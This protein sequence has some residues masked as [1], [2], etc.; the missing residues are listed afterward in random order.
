M[1]TPD[2]LSFNVRIWKTEVYT[3][4]RKTTYT[5]RWRVGKQSFREPHGSKAQADAFRS[6]LVLAQGNGEAFS[7]RNGLPVSLLRS[8]R[9][10]ENWLAFA[11]RY[12]DHKWDDISAKH[13]GNIAFTLMMATP[14]M[15]TTER[16]K[17]DDALL[18]AALRKWAFSK[19]RR[20][21][22]KAP[23]EVENALAW[24][25]ENTRM[26]SEL[27]DPKI[28]D[29]M[30]RASTTTLDGAKASVSSRK[31]NH[32]MLK[33]AL[34]FA[35]DEGILSENPIGPL[36]LKAS[37][38]AVHQ[39]D[40]RTVVNHKQA[41]ALLEAVRG[42]GHEEEGKRVGRKSGP[43]LVAFFAC[44]YY[45]G[46]RPEEA[47]NLRKRNL[48][49]TP[50]TQDKDEEGDTTLSYDW[51]WI[52][53]DEVTPDAQPEFTDNGTSR[54]ERQQLKQREPG[55]TRP[56]PCP[57]ELTQML[58]EHLERFG[59]DADG[60]LFTGVE[61]KPLATVTYRRAWRW[62]R[63]QALTGEEQASPLAATPY[64]LRHTCV[65]TWLNAGV[66]E[67]QVAQWAGHSVAVLK[68]IYAKCIVGEEERAMQQIT[69][70]LRRS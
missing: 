9:P 54:D 52:Y 17:P 3:G 35:V 56:V 13:R 67:T 62:A 2:D 4:A 27:A 31:R 8:E 37:A 23:I 50:P 61:G 19:T 12:V 10:D 26:V 30:V 21:S 22:G 63:E 47:I 1:H 11:C 60:R 15:Y 25:T 46:F 33:A 18:R 38:Q 49:L 16:G 68:R 43:R 28:A 7:L 29:A 70:A 24:V 41:R 39:V 69:E 14:A 36:K 42:Y 55:V 53:L 58:W 45:C 34:Q 32:G 40:R 20:H 65:S 6:K 57:P 51:S 66:S 59:T 48:S 5:V 44:M 64:S